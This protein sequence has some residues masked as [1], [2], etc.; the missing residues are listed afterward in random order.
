MM[1]NLN[2]GKLNPITGSWDGKMSESLDLEDPFDDGFYAKNR[3]TLATVELVS[4]LSVMT[5]ENSPDSRCVCCLA[6]PTGA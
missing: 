5:A 3:T 1:K 2:R 4:I 6:R